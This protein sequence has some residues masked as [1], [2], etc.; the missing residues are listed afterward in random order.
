MARYHL[1]CKNSLLLL[2]PKFQLR[3]GDKSFVF[4]IEFTFFLLYFMRCLPKYVMSGYVIIQV[5]TR[6]LTLPI[7]VILFKYLFRAHCGAHF[8]DKSNILRHYF[9]FYCCT[10]PLCSKI[11][12]LHHILATL[13]CIRH[14]W[15]LKLFF[16]TFFSEFCCVPP[17]LSVVIAYFQQS[18]RISPYPIPHFAHGTCLLH[19]QPPLVTPRFLLL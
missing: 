9:V 11:L 17:V 12:I 8:R 7:Y 6:V 14:Q 13:L 18:L 2:K 19:P 4:L 1:R 5:F 15:E 3:V 10:H 16:F